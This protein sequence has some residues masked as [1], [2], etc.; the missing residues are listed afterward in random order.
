[1]LSWSCGG[2]PYDLVSVKTEQP[3]PWLAKHVCQC[4]SWQ[5]LNLCALL[6]SLVWQI[7]LYVLYQTSLR[8][9]ITKD[10]KIKFPALKTLSVSL[11]ARWRFNESE[12][13]TRRKHS[14][15]WGGGSTGCQCGAVSVCSCGYRVTAQCSSSP[16]LMWQ[17]HYHKTYKPLR[18]S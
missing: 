10:A 7:T 5:W 17:Q 18:S 16:S 6:A 4:L 12:I 3:Q 13:D 2:S 11:S 9:W 14:C 15:L 1:M 8:Q